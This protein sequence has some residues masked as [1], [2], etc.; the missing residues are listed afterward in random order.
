MKQHT[1]NPAKFALVY[2][3]PVVCQLT[4]MARGSLYRCAKAGELDLVKLGM[5]SSGITRES[6]VRFAQ[7]RSI[8]LPDGF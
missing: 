5:R 2:R 6:L 1:Q 7:A 4:G 8:P 3:I